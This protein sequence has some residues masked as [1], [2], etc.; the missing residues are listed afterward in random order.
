MS[1]FFRRCTGSVILHELSIQKNQTDI[2]PVT[3][4]A[5]ICKH[6]TLTTEIWL[7][8]KSHASLMGTNSGWAMCN[9]RVTAQYSI[10][11]NFLANTRGNTH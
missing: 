4:T 5:N 9:G 6:C 7:I 8:G 2:R 10:T 3:F 1:R 11:T